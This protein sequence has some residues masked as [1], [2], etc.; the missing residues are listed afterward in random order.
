M[1]IEKTITLMPAEGPAPMKRHS[2]AQMA[3]AFGIAAVSDVFS[4]WL[5]FA[6]PFQWTLDIATAIALFL[7]LGKR[8]ALL[9]GLIAEAIPGMGVFP[10]WVLVVLSVIVYDGIKKPVRA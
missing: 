10:V 7:I 5:T 9:P 4:I 6:P 2:R 3:I 8:W 1:A